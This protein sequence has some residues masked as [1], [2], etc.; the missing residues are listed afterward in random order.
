[1]LL[2]TPWTSHPRASKKV[3]AAEPMSPLLPVMT[4]RF[5]AVRR[6]SCAALDLWR[7][8]RDEVYR[9]AP[10]GH[11]RRGHISGPAG[12]SVGLWSLGSA[13]IRQRKQ[14]VARLRRASE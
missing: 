12:Q 3:A 13:G 2:S 14:Q 11:N 6:L 1:M 5:I 8:T 4:T 7:R 10:N 9:G